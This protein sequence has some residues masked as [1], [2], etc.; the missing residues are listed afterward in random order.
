M[1][2]DETSE[3][4]RAVTRGLIWERISW[5]INLEGDMDELKC[6]DFLFFFL[7]IMAWENKLNK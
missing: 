2:R 3:I 5:F 7:Y 1:Q 6:I 4:M